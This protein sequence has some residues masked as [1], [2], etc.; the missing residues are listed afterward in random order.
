[1]TG[2]VAP[3]NDICIHLLYTNCDSLLGD[4]TKQVGNTYLPD[5]LIKR[6]WLSSGDTDYS[7]FNRNGYQAISPSEHVR[8]LSPY[9]HTVNDII[10]LSVNNWQQSVAF[11]KLNLACVAHAA[12]IF[13]ESVDEN[14]ILDDEIVSYEVFDIYGRIVYSEKNIWKNM[15]EIRINNLESGIYIGRFFTKNGNNIIKKFFIKY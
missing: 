12:G 6:A 2:Y 3:G 4:F 8:Y 14:E 5:I 7:S 15:E 11:T 1:M 13:S 9:I 10:G